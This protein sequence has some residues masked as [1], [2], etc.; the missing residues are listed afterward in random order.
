LMF[1]QELES[2]TE[3]QM[4]VRERAAIK[5]SFL[6][7]IQD[8]VRRELFCTENGID[9]EACELVPV[10]PVDVHPRRTDYLRERFG[11]DKSTLI[12]LYQGS[13]C[14]WSC[15]E[16]FQELVS[17]WGPQR[18]LVVN[19]R[20]KPGPRLT[21]FMREL[22][23]SGPIYF[24]TDPVPADALP[25]L[26]ASADVGLVSYRPGPTN[27]ATGN[28]LRYV[29]LSSGK[30]AFYTMCG[31]PILARYLASISSTIEKGGFGRS[32]HNISEAKSHL[33]FMAANLRCMGDAARAYY[34]AAL[35]PAIPIVR[36]CDRLVKVSEQGSKTQY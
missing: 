21:E 35:S 8:E 36:F 31:L 26:T 29:G 16:Q 10:A 19:S 24:T 1:E 33:D 34:E 25:L 12:V 14:S 4:K 9:P 20:D 30:I 28:N 6:F 18:C 11:I 23:A 2:P 15:I 27:W 22:A 13:L 7:L 32:Y 3:R 5:R 17:S